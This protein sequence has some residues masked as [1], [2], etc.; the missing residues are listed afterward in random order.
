MGV[1]WTG[2]CLSHWFSISHHDFWASFHTFPYLAPA[3]REL[4]CAK[5][6]LAPLQLFLLNTLCNCFFYSNISIKVLPSVFCLQEIH[7]NL[8]LLMF[9][10]CH[11]QKLCGFIHFHISSLN[12]SWIYE[13]QENLIKF[14]TLISGSRSPVRI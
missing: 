13:I 9:L 11:S 4:H 14:L 3:S 5:S 12:T 7:S 10:C 2:T 1:A 8:W 6:L